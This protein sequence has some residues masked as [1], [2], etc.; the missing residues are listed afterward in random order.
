[1]GTDLDAIR[2][3]YAGALLSSVLQGVEAEIGQL[4]RIMMVENST[5]AAFM[6]G[7]PGVNREGSGGIL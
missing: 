2:A 4:G 3:Y 7:T 1:M 5:D 6:S